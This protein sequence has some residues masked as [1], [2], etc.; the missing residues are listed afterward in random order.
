MI[1]SLSTVA[2][3]ITS[4]AFLLATSGF[5]V[6]RALAC[7]DQKVAQN[8][9]ANADTRIGDRE[10]DLTAADRDLGVV[11][12]KCENAL[13]L[14]FVLL[15]AYTGLAIIFAAKNIVRSEDIEN[16]TQ[17]YLGGTLVN[18]TYSVLVGA[19]VLAA[20]GFSSSINAVSISVRWWISAIFGVLA[21]VGLVVR[22]VHSR[23]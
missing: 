13:V 11:S 1:P 3:F 5:V 21:I 17:Y 19:I 15:E 7:I 4:Y 8:D 18:F 23:P 20:F 12:G 6:D 22:F 16:N 2:L 9:G 14:T 10:D